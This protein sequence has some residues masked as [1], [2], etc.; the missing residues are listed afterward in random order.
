MEGFSMSIHRRAARRDD[1][2]REI[3]DALRQ[4]GAT[5]QQISVKGAPDLLVG[6]RGTNF[7]LEIKNQNGKLTH[8]EKN[9]I[10]GWA[11][12]VY[13]VQTPEEALQAIGL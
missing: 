11:G 8:D 9:W 2:E 12:R 7:L 6:F 13:I 10:S 3:I 1:N 5:V 4:V